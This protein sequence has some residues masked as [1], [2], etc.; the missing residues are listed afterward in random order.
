MQAIASSTKEA[1]QTQKALK[2]LATFQ[3]P[4]LGD[5]I[6][7]LE[8]DPAQDSV[9]ASDAK[10]VTADF[11]APIEQPQK[12]I[13]TSNIRVYRGI[14]R[15]LAGM[16]HS[17]ERI[18]L[19]AGADS[20]VTDVVLADTIESAVGS[21]EVLNFWKKLNHE[22][23]GLAM[24]GDLSDPS[25]YDDEIKSLPGS[26]KQML[27]MVFSGSEE[28]KAWTTSRD[29]SS[30]LVW[31]IVRVD[32]N[33]NHRKRNEKIR[34]VHADKIGVSFDDEVVLSVMN[35]MRSQIKTAAQE[36]A[37]KL[38]RCGKVPFV[39]IPAPPD[40]LCAYHSLVGSL[41]YPSWG[42]VTRHPNGIAVN[43]RISRSES[44]V[45]HQLREYAL[46]QTPENDPIIAE[47]A[48]EAQQATTL[49]IGELFSDEAW[50]YE[51]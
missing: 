49:D 33:H 5:I 48:L 6:S 32:M 35:A 20:S 31:S 26:Q 15:R 17:D 29:T 40:G 9:V 47:Q 2:T 46:L 3:G 19:L 39:R 24:F 18:A 45:A 1:V 13:P 50:W 10:D 25:K 44:D 27:L 43:R 41:T 42:Q 11:L 30:E 21:T 36:A 37:S 23:L 34:F 12:Q 38:E 28:P 22:V 14:L 16:K 51:I 8:K 7:K 4:E